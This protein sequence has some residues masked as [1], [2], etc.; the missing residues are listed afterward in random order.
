MERIKEALDRAREQREAAGTASGL[1]A[2][3]PERTAADAQPSALRIEYSQTRVIQPDPVVMRDSKVVA[4]GGSGDAVADAYR[5][6][7]TRALRAMD[8]HGWSS[9]AI[10]SPG[11]G[12]GKSL[13]AV[14]LALS[15]AREINRTVLLVDL[16]LRRPGLHRFFGIEVDHGISE[17]LTET[18][19]IEDVLINPAIERLVILPGSGRVE[20]SSEL[21]SSPRM[22]ALTVELANRYPERVVIY[23]LPPVLMVDDALAFSPMVD[24]FLVVVE[25][26]GT[27]AEEIVAA[28]DVLAQANILGTVLNKSADHHGQYYY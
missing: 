16:D 6:L 1:A 17:Y 27:Q 25:E 15:I 9:L 12:E 20:N 13:T 11:A 14:N 26:S 18:A 23:D 24:A 28:Y 5:M 3:S 10:T 8:E 21:L 4:Q 2:R 19:R 22:Q 7:R